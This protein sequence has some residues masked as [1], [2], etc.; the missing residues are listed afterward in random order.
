MGFSCE[1]LHQL[2]VTILGHPSHIPAYKR[3]EL[4]P[5]LQE[6]YNS[7]LSR[8]IKQPNL[9]LPKLLRDVPLDKINK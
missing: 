2:W 4:P 7:Y 5:P 1:N 9:Y 3:G 6:N 8:N